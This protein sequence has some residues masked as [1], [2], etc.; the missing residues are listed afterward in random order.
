MKWILRILGALAVLVILAV[1]AL[2]VA[3]QRAEAGHSRASI[4]VAASPEQV[5]PWLN[6]PDKLKQWISWLIEVR[7]GTPAAGTKRVLVMK[8]ENNHGQL[9]EIE[10]TILDCT[11][12]SHLSMTLSVPGSFTGDHNFQ[13]TDLGSGHSRLDI[14]MGYRFDSWFA[15]LM[16]PIVSRLVRQKMESDM[17]HFKQMVEASASSRI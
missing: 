9:M 15:R 10:E 11:P 3:G 4:E 8:D 1:A 13:V 14:Q 17:A 2:A 6:D 5:W 16:E 12:P 7:G